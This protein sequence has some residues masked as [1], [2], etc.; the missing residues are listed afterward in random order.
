MS[1]KCDKPAG[2]TLPN[3]KMKDK[4]G[5]PSETDTLCISCNKLI[6]ENG[7]IV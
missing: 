1:H 4:P 6:D 2:G 7:I 5:I 3:K